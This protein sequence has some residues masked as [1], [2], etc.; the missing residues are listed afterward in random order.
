MRGE[1]HEGQRRTA[2]AWI[3]AYRAQVLLLYLRPR[4]TPGFPQG[5]L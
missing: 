3:T 2:S 4:K 5:G 1:E